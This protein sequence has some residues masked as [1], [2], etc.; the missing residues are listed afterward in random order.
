MGPSRFLLSS[1]WCRPVTRAV[2]RTPPAP[3]VL[4]GRTRQIPAIRRR[5]S[6]AAH[7]R[8]A[9]GQRATSPL[10]GLVARWRR[11]AAGRD[12]PVLVG[13]GDAPRCRGSGDIGAASATHQDAE[14]G[15]SPAT[16]R[17]APVRAD[18]NPLGH[19]GSVRWG[20]KDERTAGARYRRIG[21][22][23]V[24]AGSLLD[25]RGEAG[26]MLELNALP[27]AF[28]SMSVARRKLLVAD[29]RSAPKIAGGGS[30]A[31]G[32]LYSRVSSRAARRST[33]VWALAWP[34]LRESGG[35]CVAPVRWSSPPGRVGAALATQTA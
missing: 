32:E 11:A 2:D 22:G 19:R 17:K 31:I 35:G 13:A 23:G 7:C 26:A 15:P 3:G 27:H 29:F 14:Q 6:P 24:R 21:F 18:A 30:D 4:E 10:T 34:S 1:R 12:C 25:P 20:R 28:R 8:N 16:R 5:R 9:P 33:S